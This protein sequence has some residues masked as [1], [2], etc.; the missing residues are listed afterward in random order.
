MIQ[1]EFKFYKPCKLLQPYVRYY[2]TSGIIGYSRAID[3]WMPLLILSVALKSFS[4]N[5]HRFIS[6]N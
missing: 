3:R 2:C 6:Q 4:I 1:D 5:K